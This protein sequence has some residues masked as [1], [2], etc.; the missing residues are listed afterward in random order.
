MGPYILAWFPMVAIAILNA[1]VREW[2]YAKRLSEPAAHQVSTLS[3]LVLLG[4]YMAVVIR[5]WRPA[6]AGQC[7]AVGLV[8][9]VLT[10][11]FE[12]VFGHYGAGHSWSRLLHDYNVFAGRVWILVPL[13]VAVAPILLYRL[14]G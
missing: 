9:L 14:T 4:V 12:F 13:W 10:V 7:I 1:A 2:G 6:S 11:G 3:A 8:W 5:V